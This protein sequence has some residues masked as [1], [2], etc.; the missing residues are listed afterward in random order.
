M[1]ELSFR[2]PRSGC[3][4]VEVSNLSKTFGQDCK[5]V[6]DVSFSVFEREIFGF[7]GPNGAGKTTTINVLT[8]QIRPSSGTATVAGFD[9]ARNPTDVRKRI[10]VVPQNNTADEELTGRENA[11]VI[12][13]L[14][15]I[16]KI[17]RDKIVSG[18][19]DLVELKEVADKLVRNY[20]GGMR[21][22]LEIAS[23]F[24]SRPKVLFLDEPTLGLDTQTREAV[25]KYVKVLRDEYST[26]VFLTTHLMEEADQICDRL[27]II[28]HGKLIKIGTPG[29]IKS[30]VGSDI[31]DLTLNIENDEILRIIAHQIGGKIDRIGPANYRV[32]VVNGEEAIPQIID[33]VRAIGLKVQRVSLSKPSLAEAYL[34]LT[35]RAF[36]D[37]D[38]EATQTSRMI[39]LFG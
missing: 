20:S 37:A 22:R 23:G 39:N 29:E 24:I 27:A 10:S 32:K 31:I 12:A 21:R 16:P 34:D 6:D 11:E 25:W 33:H 28:D 19:L 4:I 18:V 9:V 35:G 26:T 17:N 30:V 7:L 8:T 5:A 13:N 2:E 14:Y 1:Q 3:P 38:L 36:R 15:G